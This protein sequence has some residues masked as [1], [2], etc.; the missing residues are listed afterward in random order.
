MTLPAP[1]VSIITITYNQEKY[2]REA[3]DSL[4][5]QKTSFPVEC[6]VADDAST[7][8]TG[9][10]VA[11]YA[12]KHSNF[13][14]P[15]LRKKNLGAVANFFDA[16]QTAKGDYIAL[17]EG[18]DFWLDENKLQ[19]QVEFLEKNPDHSLCFHSTNVFFQDRSVPDS[20]FPDP[21]DVTDLTVERLVRANFIQTN[22]VLY[23]RQ[24]YKDMNQKAFPTDW[25]LHLYH[26]Q[27]GKIGYINRVMSAY[28]R[29]PGGLWWD[30]HQNLDQ[31]WRKHG[32][33][34][35]ELYAE[36]LRMYPE[37]YQ[38]KQLIDGK[39]AALFERLQILDERELYL[40]AAKQYPSFL[41]E[42]I[43]SLL[44]RIAEQGHQISQLEKQSNEL[45]TA[46]SGAREEITAAASAI[47]ERDQHLRSIL[48][49]KS[50]KLITKIRRVLRRH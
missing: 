16:L 27:Y 26:A 19:L 18:D 22:S 32:L 15:I 17:C 38:V 48:N 46:L 50:W 24:S 5:A 23:R 45:R 33:G 30:T 49:S 41:L 20:I 36:V 14:R 40:G 29:H 10:I 9:E 47:Q 6:I 8:S 4:I 13:F 35:L 11:Q 42:H 31:I 2:V 3:L 44:A 12:Q 7:D 43:H 1:K 28:R 21:N 37:N 25:Y 34:H 39:A